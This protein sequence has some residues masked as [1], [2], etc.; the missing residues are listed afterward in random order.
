MKIVINLVADMR[1]AMPSMKTGV[2]IHGMSTESKIR[3]LCSFVRQTEKS[4]T[5]WVDCNGN[6]F[7]HY[8]GG[9][10]QDQVP[11]RM[12]CSDVTP[13]SLQMVVF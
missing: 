11:V 5:D 12:L 13:F 10:Q 2:G 6:S 1:L 9:Y 3:R 4:S 8:F 7:S